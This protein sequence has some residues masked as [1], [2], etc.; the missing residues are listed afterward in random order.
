MVV[1]NLALTPSGFRAVCSE[2]M[3]GLGPLAVY[4]VPLVRVPVM[5]PELW[6]TV[7]V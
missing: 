5:T 6:S 4:L 2:S 3:T 1:T 7:A